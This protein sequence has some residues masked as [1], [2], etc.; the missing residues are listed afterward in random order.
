MNARL[1]PTKLVN[2]IMVGF[3]SKGSE[4]G[5]MQQAE[6]GLAARRTILSSALV[7]STRSRRGRLSLAGR[8][9][10]LRNATLNRLYLQTWCRHF[11]TLPL[12]EAEIRKNYVSERL[13]QVRLYPNSTSYVVLRYVSL[14]C[15]YSLRVDSGIWAWN[16]DFT[17]DARDRFRRYS[18]Y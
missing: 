16:N 12:I 13:E 9:R 15:C 2:V 5:Q 3:G 6:Y 10:T 8:R 4:Y 11:E 14:S 18:G 7:V 1:G 17:K